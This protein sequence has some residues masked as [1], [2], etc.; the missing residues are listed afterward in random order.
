VQV[1][2]NLIDFGMNVQEAGDAARVRHFGS[3]EPTG[4]PG[5]PDG[6]TIAVESGISDEAI[7]RL[8]ALGHRVERVPP[9]GNFGGYQGILIDS[10]HGTLHGGTDPRKDGCA[11]GY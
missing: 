10:Q 9:G 5:D 8:K 2:V 4:Q 11:A 6:G 3:A 7:T 1:L